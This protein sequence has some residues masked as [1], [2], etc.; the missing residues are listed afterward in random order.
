MRERLQLVHH[1]AIDL[2]HPT[3]QYNWVDLQHVKPLLHELANIGGSLTV[4]P[5]AAI[6]V[7]PEE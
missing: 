7:D 4:V 5:P 1:M 3:I 6:T 2:L